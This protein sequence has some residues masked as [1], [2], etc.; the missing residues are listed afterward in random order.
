MP[1]R[2]IRAVL[3]A[4][5]TADDDNVL[6]RDGVVATAS[7]VLQNAKGCCDLQ[8]LQGDVRAKAF[9]TSVLA[10]AGEAIE[11]DLVILMFCGHGDEEG[12]PEKGWY[13]TDAR[14]GPSDIRELVKEFRE[15]TEV[16]VISDCCFGSHVLDPSR[17]PAQYQHILRVD[18]DDAFSRIR[19]TWARI[20]L[21]LAEL[22]RA[23]LRELSAEL[24]ARKLQLNADIILISSA[25]AGI[26]RFGPENQFVRSVCEQAPRC[27]KYAELGHRLA[28]LSV[29]AP[30][31]WSLAAR[32][33]LMPREPLRMKDASRSVRVI[34]PPD[35]PEPGRKTSL[36]RLH[37]PSSDT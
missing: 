15:G 27:L 7:F 24:T 4:P 5:R 32:D 16:V 10:Q 3:A 14:I 11:D 18:H 30:G 22:S 35:E 6:G 28:L 23:W 19:D 13:F 37:R 33:E 26:A 2:N 12:S 20:R 9:Q 29:Y 34:E 25:H 8:V 36:P 31:V 17:D 21:E 1:R